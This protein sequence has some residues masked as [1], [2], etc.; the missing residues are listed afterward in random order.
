MDE[1]G[2]SSLPL[3][4]A[5]ALVA[6]NA[7]LAAAEF[8]LI[9]VR[10]SRIEQ[11]VRLGDP[12]SQR[13]LPP[14][15]RL[16]TLVFSA[17]LSRSTLTVLLG[18]YALLA[19]R[20]FW[21]P[22]GLLPVPAAV[23]SMAIAILLHA[24]LGQQIPKLIAVA[25][26]E[27]ITAH[28]SIPFLELLSVVLY[29]VTRPLTVIV[30]GFLRVFGVKSAGFHPLM[31]TPEELRMLVT[32]GTDPGEIESDERDMIRG[33]F[34]F[35]ETIAREVMTPRTAMVALPVETGFDE[36]IRIAIEEGHSRYPVYEGT[37]D[38]IVGVVLEKDLL[39]LMAR[40]EELEQTGFDI[41]SILRPAY[42]VPGTKSVA[43]LL[44]ELRKQK[45]H[46][47]IVL[48]EYGGTHGLVTM[49]D[50]LEEIV[51]EIADEFDEPEREFEPT[52]EGDV[53]IDGA[54]SLGEVNER[55]GLRLPEEE[56][57]T[58][59]G[60]VFG[61]LGRVPVV[62]DVVPA[63]GI[64]GDMELRVDETEER[65]V[66]LVRLMQPASAQSVADAE[67]RAEAAPVGE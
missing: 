17:Q 54:V 4:I 5:L 53:L 8:A 19:A 25:R 15:E 62:G 9:A 66:T 39:P 20:R 10:R 51:G 36:L 64:D 47:A 38:S 44:Q 49:E 45:V 23:L 32:H 58:L 11:N 59:G 26:A 7:F 14:I 63:P 31:Q 60:Y 30:R 48:D 56:F 28:V 16:E 34:E 52:P 3:F 18:Y 1:P 37:V 27:W 24:T 2:P 29:P 41:R 35:A 67:A 6:A 21:E 50:L 46:L 43:E 42:F 40:R 65:R 22:L 57:D 55:F 12:R 13:I 61:T 33:V